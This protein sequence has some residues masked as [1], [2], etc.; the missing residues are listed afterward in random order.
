[1]V[2]NNNRKKGKRKTRK[3]REFSGE[4]GMTDRARNAN[5]SVSFNRVPPQKNSKLTASYLSIEFQYLKILGDTSRRIGSIRSIYR[6][7]FSINRI[8]IEN[9]D[10]QFIRINS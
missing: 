2:K 5:M 10:G 6:F 9:T 8:V 7:S 3:I 4:N 1:M